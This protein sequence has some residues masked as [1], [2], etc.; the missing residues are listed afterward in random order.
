MDVAGNVFRQWMDGVDRARY[1]D[2][3]DAR[4]ALK[5]FV[6]HA[7]EEIKNENDLKRSFVSLDLHTIDVKI[8]LT[9]KE[10][11]DID[12]RKLLNCR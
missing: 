4:N 10:I 6:V 1:M 9:V 12:V 8:P 5:L 3:N 2:D 11:E 7:L